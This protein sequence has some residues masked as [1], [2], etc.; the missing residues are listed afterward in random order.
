VGGGALLAAA[1]YG[2][3]WYTC[4]EGEHRKAAVEWGRAM[5]GRLK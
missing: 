5:L 4:V 3:A 2:I 1:Y